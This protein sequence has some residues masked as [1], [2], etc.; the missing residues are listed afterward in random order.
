[1]EAELTWKQWTDKDGIQF[2]IVRENIAEA[3]KE[4]DKKISHFK[5]HYNVKKIQENYFENCLF[6]LKNKDSL[7]KYAVIQI[8]FAENYSLTFQD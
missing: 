2:T 8:D 7:E 1:M 5:I 4:L 3:I 6:D